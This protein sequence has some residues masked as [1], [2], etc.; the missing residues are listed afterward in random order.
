MNALG[1]PTGV[2]RSEVSQIVVC[3]EL[4]FMRLRA[5]L[6]TIL[7]LAVFHVAP[8]QAAPRHGEGAR[9]EVSRRT[10][11]EDRAV[12]RLAFAP[13]TRTTDAVR[14]FVDR[15]RTERTIGSPTKAA[16]ARRS[17]P[18][19]PGGSMQIISQTDEDERPLPQR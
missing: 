1:A 7:L 16:S 5:W 8:L 12:P 19:W 9:N 2:G 4:K 15:F 13:R 10:S 14:S 18:R 3:E 11:T 17:A 6:G